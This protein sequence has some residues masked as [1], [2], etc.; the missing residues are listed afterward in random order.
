MK[1]LRWLVNPDEGIFFLSL[2]LSAVFFNRF[3]RHQDF[4][5][6]LLL[7][8][9][10]YTVWRPVVWYVQRIQA[11]YPRQRFVLG[12]IPLR[13]LPS[14]A[15]LLAIS[16]GWGLYTEPIILRYAP[17]TSVELK[18]NNSITE[19]KVVVQLSR[20]VVLQRLDKSIV[21]IESSNIL[22][23]SRPEDERSLFHHVKPTPKKQVPFPPHQEKATSSLRPWIP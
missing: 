10:A 11:N 18:Q 21:A 7:L 4:W 23:M 14:F 17:L 2:I 8:S 9:N 16:F 12:F 5:A 15:F 1:V 19:G 3:L 22:K 20:F 13:A 6:L